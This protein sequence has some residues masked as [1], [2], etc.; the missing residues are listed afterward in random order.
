MANQLKKINVFKNDAGKFVCAF[1]AN[2]ALVV[3]LVCENEEA[4]LMLAA[5]IS[6]SVQQADVGE[7]AF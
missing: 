6:N 1:N 7:V 2:G 4:A 5:Q 3:T